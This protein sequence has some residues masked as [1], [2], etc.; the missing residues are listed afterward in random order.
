MTPDL[1]H[2]FELASAPDGAALVFAYAADGLRR[3][4]GSRLTT[5]SVYDLAQMRSRR[6]YTDDAAAYPLGNFK[7]LDRNRYF[8]LVI[9]GQDIHA[10]TTIEQIAGVFFD[11]RKIRDLGCES[12]LNLPAIA[13]GRVIGSIN[14]LDR[15][16]HYAPD[17]VQAARAWQ[18]VATLAF[19]LLHEAGAT[20]F[21]GGQSAPDPS[22]AV[23]EG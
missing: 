11:W 13:G 16:G 21:H 2:A 7:R 8:E 12:C 10:A 1:Q 17:R 15:K 3:D 23:M 14:M 4:V 9:E 18:P 5:A 19:L 22:L 6:V 20:S